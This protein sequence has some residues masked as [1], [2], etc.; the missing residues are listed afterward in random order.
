MFHSEGIPGTY[1][2]MQRFHRVTE[3]VYRDSG[4]CCPVSLMSRSWLGQEDTAIA[5]IRLAPTP[6]FYFPGYRFGAGLQFLE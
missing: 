4:P 6:T 3:T 2:E 1:S 5:R